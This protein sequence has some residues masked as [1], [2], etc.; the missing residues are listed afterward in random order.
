SRWPMDIST[1]HA[2]RT[3][4]DGSRQLCIREGPA[5]VCYR[6]RTQLRLRSKR[7]RATSCWTQ[8]KGSRRNQSGLQTYLHERPEHLAGARKGSEDEIRRASSRIPGLRRQRKKTRHLSG[9]A[10]YARRN[11]TLTLLGKA[12]Q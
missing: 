7:R 5:A 4:C 12:H 2:R 8:R 9:Q 10:W 6:S 3:T 11:L 1:D